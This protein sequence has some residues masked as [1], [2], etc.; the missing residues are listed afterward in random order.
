MEILI[1]GICAAFA[2]LLTFF[3]GFG[4]GTLLTPVFMIFFPIEIAI[5]LTGIVHLLNNL[6]KAVLIGKHANW[7][8]LL[9]FGIPA[10]FGAFAGAY[11]LT[12]FKTD[13]CLVEYN[14]GIRECCVTALKLIIAALMIFFAFFEMLPSLKKL[15][16][17]K[18]K[19]LFGGLISGFF[20]GL[21]GHQGALRSAFLIRFGLSKEAFIATGV[22]I[23]CFIDITRLTVYYKNIENINLQE[24][25]KVLLVAILCAFAGAFLGSKLLK[26][27][28]LAAV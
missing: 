13:I 3:S 17:G 9:R 5:A 6:F 15:E 12:N 28:T 27:V 18:D 10:I 24:N 7:N 19:L 8:I 1:I 16:F 22:F 23:A 11:L 20:G 26:K 2:S 25:Y 21:S 14:L 4:L